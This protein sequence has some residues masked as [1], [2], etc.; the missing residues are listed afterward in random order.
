[1]DRQT[2]QYL[3]ALFDMEREIPLPESIVFF[4]NDA[5]TDTLPIFHILVYRKKTAILFDLPYCI[6]EIS[7]FLRYPGYNKSFESKYHPS[8]FFAYTYRRSKLPVLD[9]LEL[10]LAFS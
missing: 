8:L 3:S 6:L 1:L 2:L 10:A 9:E 7:E 5:N 4:P